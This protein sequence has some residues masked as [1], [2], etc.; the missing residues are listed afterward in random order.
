M[1]LK[2]K[3]YELEIIQ[4]KFVCFSRDNGET[5]HFSEWSYLGPMLQEK[6]SAVREELSEMMEKF[7]N[8]KDKAAVEAISEEYRKDQPDCG[9]A[10]T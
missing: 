4:G 6:F 3:G 8:S 7:I 10:K 1:L 2:I 5:T 9:V